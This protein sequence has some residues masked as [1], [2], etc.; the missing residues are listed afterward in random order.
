VNVEV[1]VLAKM[2]E[3]SLTGV[4]D[5]AKA[6]MQKD[7]AVTLGKLQ[8][9]ITQLEATVAELQSSKK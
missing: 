2:V 1:D 8:E 5:T 4:Y 3:R 6:E 7:L 9:R